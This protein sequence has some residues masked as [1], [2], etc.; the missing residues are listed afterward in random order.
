MNLSKFLGFGLLILL[1]FASIHLL[2]QDPAAPLPPVPAPPA[3]GTAN[4][5]FRVNATVDLVNVAVTVRDSSGRCPLSG[6]RTGL[7]L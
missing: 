4:D 1:S 6:S 3:A 2:A 5:P 7:C